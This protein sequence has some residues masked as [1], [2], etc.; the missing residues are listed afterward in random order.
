M[1]NDL[2]ASSAKH[3]NASEN[4][5]SSKPEE[6]LQHLRNDIHQIRLHLE[7]LIKRSLVLSASTGMRLDPANI[8]SS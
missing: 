1:A 5:G 8:K 6:R 7:I 4:R 3:T 2:H